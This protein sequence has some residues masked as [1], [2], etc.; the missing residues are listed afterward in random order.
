MAV[1]PYT[2]MNG[3]LNVSSREGKAK[4]TFTKVVPN[5]RQVVAPSGRFEDGMRSLEDLEGRVTLPP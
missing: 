4:K 3:S 1:L 2:C 5:R